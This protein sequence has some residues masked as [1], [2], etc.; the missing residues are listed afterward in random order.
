LVALHKPDLAQKC[1]EEFAEKF[2]EEIHSV[3]YKNLVKDIEN[4]AE[5]IQKVEAGNKF[6]LQ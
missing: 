6:F 4:D 5:M 2:P 1:L 3:L